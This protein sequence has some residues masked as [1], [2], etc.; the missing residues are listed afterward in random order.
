[1][2]KRRRYG[3]AKGVAHNDT[4]SIIRAS[5]SSSAHLLSYISS[6]CMV[7]HYSTVS[8][9]RNFGPSSERLTRYSRAHEAN[10]FDT[11]HLYSVGSVM[12]QVRLVL[13]TTTNT[14]VNIDI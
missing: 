2:H 6:S 5:M 10:H 12:S 11:L 1:M 9:V 7:S 13:P 8:T 4:V 3:S 14:L